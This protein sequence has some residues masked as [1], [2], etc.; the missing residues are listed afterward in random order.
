MIYKYNPE[1]VFVR[2]QEYEWRYALQR[3]EQVLFFLFLIL[4]GKKHDIYHI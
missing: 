4:T 1:R 3:K 2:V